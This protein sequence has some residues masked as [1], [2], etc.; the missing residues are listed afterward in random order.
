MTD[1]DAMAEFSGQWPEAPDVRISV[2]S[3]QEAGLQR[4]RQ[5]T[6]TAGEAATEY[7]QLDGNGVFL[8]WDSG[9]E[10]EGRFPLA[11]RIRLAR[12]YGG[13]IFRRRVIVVEHW[14]EVT[15]P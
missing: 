11:E 15:E 7:A 4:L 5:E 9:P 8:V 12:S 10:A 3:G 6:R 1:P 2:M 14:E 13:L